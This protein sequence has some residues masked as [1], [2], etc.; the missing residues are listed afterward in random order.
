VAS[1]VGTRPNFMKIA[2][3][4]VALARRDG[5]FEHVLI[6]TDQHYDDAMS[7]VFLEELGVGE[8]Q[9]HLAVGSGPREEQIERV[10]ARLEPILRDLRPDVLLVPGDVNSTLG[11]ALAAERADVPVGHVEAGLR[12]FDPTMPEEANRVATDELSTLLF[13]HSPEARLNLLREGADER[14]IHE[15]GNTMIDTLDAMRDRIEAA[16]APERHRL[17][18]GRYLVVTLHRPAL[19][20]E[21]GLLQETMRHLTA[22]AA[23]YD[24]AFPV[25]PRTRQALDRLEG[26]AATESLKLIAPLPYVEFLSLVASAAAVITDSGGLQEETTALGVPC[27]TLRN[28]TER[29]ITVNCGTNT[30]LGLEPERLRDVPRLLA[31]FRRPSGRPPH[32]DG[33]AADRIVSVLAETDLSVLKPSRTHAGEER[34]TDG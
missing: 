15:V 1:L 16:A 5:E 21:P 14:Q 26:S 19:V 33:H 28:N 17:E 11:G 23:D 7:K 22:I 12:S 10:V 8:P 30:L 24:I 18:R 34:P 29:P 4:Q 3:I 31:E 20:D 32:W 9:F 13:T 2:P 25:H 27:F 6:H